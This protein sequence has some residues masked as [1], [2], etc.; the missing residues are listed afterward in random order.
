MIAFKLSEV[1]EL[2]LF[3]IDGREDRRSALLI[4]IP[5]HRPFELSK[6]IGK[7][8]KSRFLSS[9]QDCSTL[10]FPLSWLLLRFSHFWPIALEFC[11]AHAGSVHGGMRRCFSLS[12]SA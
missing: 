9:P 10:Y 12:V 1:K 4:A 7:T 6:N 8:S 2:P 5:R 11:S 3:S